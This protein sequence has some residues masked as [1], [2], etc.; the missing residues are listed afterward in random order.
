MVSKK[1]EFCRAHARSLA[2]ENMQI[3]H[4]VRNDGTRNRSF[5]EK[6]KL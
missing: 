4:C 6:L 5:C 3:S 2:L 1:V